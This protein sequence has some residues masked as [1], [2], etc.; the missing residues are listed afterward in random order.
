M[1][2]KE[3]W[4]AYMRSE[5]RRAMFFT[6]PVF[7]LENLEERLAETHQSDFDVFLVGDWE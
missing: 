4:E 3:K 1:E 5:Y 7:G 2:V 6:H